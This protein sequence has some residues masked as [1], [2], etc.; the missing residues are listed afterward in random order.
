MDRRSLLKLLAVGAG[1]YCLSPVFTMA[2]EA[3]SDSGSRKPAPFDYEWLKG[4][5]RYLSEQAFESHE[6]EL[7]ES[8]QT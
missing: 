7:P 4:R 6:G 8:L 5:A 1:G 2:E 3:Q